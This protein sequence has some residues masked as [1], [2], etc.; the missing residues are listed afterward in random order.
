MMKGTRCI[1]KATTDLFRLLLRK[2]QTC[3]LAVRQCVLSPNTVESSDTTGL[4][5]KKLRPR[6]G[7]TVR[8]VAS[9]L[10]RRPSDELERMRQKGDS[11]TAND[12]FRF[13]Y[14]YQP[15]KDP[16]ENKEICELWLERLHSI[17]KKFCYLAWYA[18]AIYT[19]YYRLSPLIID[20]EKKRELWIEVKREYAEIF[21][22]GRRIWRRPT[23]PTRLRVVYDL[24]MLCV[25]FNDLEKDPTIRKFHD[26]FADDNNFNFRI[27]D[28]VQYAQSIDKVVNLENHVIELFFQRRRSGNSNRSSI[29]SRTSSETL[30][31]GRNNSLTP[32]NSFREGDTPRGSFRARKNSRGT[33]EPS[34]SEKPKEEAETSGNNLLSP[35][36]GTKRGSLR[37]HRRDTSPGSSPK[38]VRFSPEEKQQQLTAKQKE[39]ANSEDLLLNCLTDAKKSAFSTNFN[40]QSEGK[41]A[42]KKRRSTIQVID[43]DTQTA[44]KKQLELTMS[45]EAITIVVTK[46]DEQE[47]ADPAQES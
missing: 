31:E 47:E 22:L 42:L 40:E 26:L 28:E 10:S 25:R 8:R 23:H 33:V 16:E 38:F 2:Y 1:K 11:W 45:A 32:R 4:W 34:D 30:R 3:I 39:K 20:P 19:C 7:C 43:Y 36:N 13:Q 14:A 5:R 21:Q 27:Q 18:S 24:G 37:L 9:K 6:P 35:E 41:R 17:T 29:R 15:S 46:H 44:L 12:L